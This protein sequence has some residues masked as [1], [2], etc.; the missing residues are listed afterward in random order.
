MKKILLSLLALTL[1]VSAFAMD[2]RQPRPAVTGRILDENHSPIAYA[3]ITAIDADSIQRGGITSNEEGRF[4]LAVEAGN[5]T[6]MVR[7]IGYTQ[8]SVAVD[9]QSDTDLG[10]IVLQP[11]ANEIQGVVVK[12]QMI[13]RK[14]DR[15]VVD[16]ANNPAEVIGKE[17]H[18]HV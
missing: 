9:L 8:Y 1:A 15:F 4:T 16:V 6:V 17:L 14:A 11:Q 18:N 2:A 10:D 13:T 12:A 3:T 5:Y 7:Y